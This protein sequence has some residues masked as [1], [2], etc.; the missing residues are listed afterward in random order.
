MEFHHVG[1][2][3]LKL[4]TSGDS[5]ASAS[6]NA[7]IT[8]VSHRT[9]PILAFKL[10]FSF[11]FL[12]SHHLSPEID[13]IASAV[14]LFPESAIPCLAFA[15]AVPAA[16][17]A[18][19]HTASLCLNITLCR[20]VYVPCDWHKAWMSYPERAQNF[21]RS[22][23]QSHCHH[24]L[25]KSDIAPGSLTSVECVPPLFLYYELLKHVI[26]YP[27]RPGVAAHTCNP[28]TLGGRGGRTTQGQEF[29]TNLANMLLRR[30]RQE[31]RLN[32]GGGGCSELRSHCCTPAWAT[33]SR[34]QLVLVA[35]ASNPSSLGGRDGVLLLFPRMECKGAISVP[36]NLCLLG[37]NDSPASASQV[38]E[39]TGMHHH[40]IRLANFVFLVETGFLHV[41]QDGLELPT[42]GDPPTSASQSVGITDNNSKKRGENLDYTDLCFASSALAAAIV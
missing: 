27:T 32:L 20:G 8:G 5:P 42:S 12:C 28:S 26:K 7:E 37:S 25:W 19:G 39:I 3:G 24:C 34:C 9:Q 41:G 33:E 31:H 40:K 2:V 15:R 22:G 17:D 11:L 21:S 38:T 23:S 4:L 10:C 36:C 16:W 18:M 35:H 30:L 13:P 29:K 14:A 6:Q 1:Q